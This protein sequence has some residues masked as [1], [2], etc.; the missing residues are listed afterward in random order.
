MAEH[1]KATGD[2][3]SGDD[4][5]VAALAEGKVRRAKSEGKVRHPDSLCRADTIRSP[6]ADPHKVCPQRALHQLERWQRPRIALTDAGEQIMG[7]F[8]WFGYCGSCAVRPT[9]RTDSETQ[10]LGRTCGPGSDGDIEASLEQAFKEAKAEVFP[11]KTTQGR[12]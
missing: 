6:D 10:R 12:S 9:R 11:E 2:L 5:L 1:C 4:A 7:V 8:N 3:W